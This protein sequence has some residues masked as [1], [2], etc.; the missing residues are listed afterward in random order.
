M[1]I[2]DEYS[3]IFFTSSNISENYCIFSSILDISSLTLLI[4]HSIRSEI[5][6]FFFFTQSHFVFLLSRLLIVKYETY[7]ESIFF[8][9]DT[10][11]MWRDWFGIV[12]WIF[13][14]NVSNFWKIDYELLIFISSVVNIHEEFLEIISFIFAHNKLFLRR[15]ERGVW[16]SDQ[17][18]WEYG[19]DTN[20]R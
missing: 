3:S 18:D 9:W 20:I 7:I 15:N 17:V 13:N 12:N 5:L 6:G 11:R 19:A 14:W 4:L 2:F 10:R 1:K 16:S 8:K